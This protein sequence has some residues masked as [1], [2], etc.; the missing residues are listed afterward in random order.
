MIMVIFAA[1]V[2]KDSVKHH[3]VDC[4]TEWYIIEKRKRW[5]PSRY[6]AMEIHYQGGWNV[7]MMQSC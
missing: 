3:E 2:G 5:I 1:L 6:K 4:D 7:N